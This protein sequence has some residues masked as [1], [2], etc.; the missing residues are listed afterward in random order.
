MSKTLVPIAPLGTISTPAHELPR[1]ADRPAW[2]PVDDRHRRCKLRN[3]RGDRTSQSGMRNG[4]PLSTH[5]RL[6]RSVRIRIALSGTSLRPFLF[7]VDN[8]AAILF[9]E[10]VELGALYQWG[11]WPE[12]TNAPEP[13]DTTAP[14]PWWKLWA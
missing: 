5:V 8:N 3:P 13:S 4:G 2:Y 7:G 6:G 9:R 1:T 14:T 11:V 12:R 10:D